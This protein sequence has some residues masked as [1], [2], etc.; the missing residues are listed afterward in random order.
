M[1]SSIDDISSGTLA[2]QIS[3][4]NLREAIEH[5]I[6]ASTSNFPSWVSPWIQVHLDQLVEEGQIACFDD[7]WSFF[8]AKN[9]EYSEVS[10]VNNSLSSLTLTELSSSLV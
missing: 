8:A 10:C 6:L 9:E 3:R 2:L 4:Q 7:L 5:I 1:N